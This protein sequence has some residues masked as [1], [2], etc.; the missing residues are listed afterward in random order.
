MQISSYL[1]ILVNIKI[2]SLPFANES[3][4]LDCKIYILIEKYYKVLIF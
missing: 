1:G 4:R 2:K 3:K